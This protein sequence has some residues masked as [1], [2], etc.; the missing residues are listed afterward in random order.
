MKKYIK[1]DNFIGIQTNIQKIIVFCLVFGKNVKPEN[2]F[3]LLHILPN[4]HTHT[5]I[6]KSKINLYK[7]Q[8]L[9]RWA[10]GK[11]TYCS[12]RGRKPDFQTYV[13]WLTIYNL[14]SRASN[15]L[16]CPL[17][18]HTRTHTYPTQTQT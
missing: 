8:G 16:F 10:T 2:I 7:V 6:I 15:A 4:T 5:H 17:C 3:S 1:T 14:S 18:V 13:W 11:G 12:C 9:G